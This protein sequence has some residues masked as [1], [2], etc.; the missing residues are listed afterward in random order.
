MEAIVADYFEML[1]LELRGEPYVKAEHRRRLQEVLDGRTEGSIEYKHQNISAVLIELG[2]PYIDGYKPQRNYQQLLFEVI[3]ERLNQSEG[4]LEA[5]AEK[6]DE[7]A[8]APAVEDLLDRIVDPPP[9]SDLGGGRYVR[10]RAHRAP[11]TPNFLL[12]EARNASLGRAGEEFVINVERARLLRHGRD[13]LAA[14]LEH[15]AVT[16]GD[17]VGFD[18]LSFEPDGRERMIEVK[19][20]AFGQ[21]TPFYVSRNQVEVSGR[22]RER[23]HLCR[24]FRFRRDPK[25]FSLSGDIRSN[26]VLDASEYRARTDPGVVGG[27]EAGSGG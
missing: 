18:V 3:A 6:V 1:E 8:E 9:A 2:Q 12:R 17:H 24:V 25:L 10:E 4:L 23:Y 15:V 13:D 21:M 26:F 19:T 14:D 20:T 27:A 11:R 5:V 22:E 16:R 7:D